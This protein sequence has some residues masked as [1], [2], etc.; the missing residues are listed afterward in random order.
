MR[1][2]VALCTYNGATY[3]PAQLE[4]LLH[5]EHPPAELIVCDDQ[6]TDRTWEI[7]Q[8]FAD[9]ASFPVSLH[10]NAVR[11][12]STLNFEKAM[13]LCSCN[14]IA[15]CDQD[16]IWYPQKLRVLSAAFEDPEVLGVFSD[17]D[18]L[19][20]N[21]QIEGSL[22]RSF[23]LMGAELERFQ[24]SDPLGVMIRTNRVTGMTLML[25][26]ET[27]AH[28]LPIPANWVHDYWI[29][30]MLI[31]HGKLLACPQALVAYRVHG[32]QQLSV[33]KSFLTQVRIRGVRA[34]FGELSSIAQKDSS[35]ALLQIEVL[36][37]RLRQGPGDLAIASAVARL[38][39]FMQYLRLRSQ[40]QQWNPFRRA[41]AIVVNWHLYKLFA[42]RVTRDR[43]VDLFSIQPSGSGS[44]TARVR[45]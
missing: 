34:V 19:R 41:A 20:E 6:S 10:R 18:L 22:W 3:L 15:L 38:H 17:G 4:S 1:V 37:D 12:G 30:F 31:L 23:G 8:E 36:V 33:P 35:R 28:I 5:Q 40:I 43:L 27:L 24:H 32:A 39:G 25:L 11:L 2:S 13:G 7:L 26:R 45:N 42:P 44:Q 14:T 9:R 16:D 21:Q 29:G